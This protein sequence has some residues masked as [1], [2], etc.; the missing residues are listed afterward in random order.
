MSPVGQ[1]IEAD[2]AVGSHGQTLL[3][4]PD[5]DAPFTLQVGDPAI[6]AD[7]ERL[8]ELARERSDMEPLVQAYRR[9]TALSADAGGGGTK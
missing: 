3:H 1:G 7:Y 2:A 6:I 4:G 8:T 9:H 5:R